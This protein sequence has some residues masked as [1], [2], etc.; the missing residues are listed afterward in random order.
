[1]HLCRVSPIGM[2]VLRCRPG[3]SGL[4]YLIVC[5]FSPVGLSG[6]SW[7]HAVCVQIVAV[8]TP[9]DSSGNG[10]ANGSNAQPDLALIGI[11]VSSPYPM[12]PP[13]RA[14]APGPPALPPA[15]A[16]AVQGNSSNSTTAPAPAPA[17][18]AVNG[19]SGPAVPPATTPAPAAS[20]NPLGGSL[21]RD[22][23]GSDMCCSSAS[24]MLCSSPLPWSCICGAHGAPCRGL[25]CRLNVTARV[26]ISW[27]VQAPATSGRRRLLAPSP[28]VSYDVGGAQHVA[29][30]LT[31][32][33]QDSL[34]LPIQRTLNE[35][36]RGGS[37][38]QT[39][40]NSGT[41][42]PNIRLALLF[43]VSNTSNTAP[44]L[45]R[46]CTLQCCR[47]GLKPWSVYTHLIP[48]A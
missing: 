12:P 45:S 16:S 27:A 28:T 14:P 8:I 22:S 31:I 34:M 15:L 18:A 33:A 13:A 25:W 41:S 21:V 7:R 36:I 20:N 1:M 37:F 9:Q 5:W 32:R 26:N 6:A 4:P 2:S 29:V 11:P 35:S 10:S 43:L 46:T 30:N 38:L 24:A 39:V 3:M 48:F 40:N 23:H 44:T 47:Q 19:S 42:C 17:A